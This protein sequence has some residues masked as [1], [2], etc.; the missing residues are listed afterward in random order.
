MII[1]FIDIAIQWW[2][3]HFFYFGV[4]SIKICSPQ[5]EHDQ[6]IGDFFFLQKPKKPSIFGIFRRL[7]ILS[8]CGW[9]PLYKEV[10]WRKLLIINNLRENSSWQPK[11]NILILLR[12][13]GWE[14]IEKD[15]SLTFTTNRPNFSIYLSFPKVCVA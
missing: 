6:F 5:N 8:S 2:L 13:L 11:C 9:T 10:L 7:N 15:F 3:F 12:C 1:S 14:W 4:F